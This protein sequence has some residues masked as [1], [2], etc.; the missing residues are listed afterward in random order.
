MN[1]GI[2][3]ALTAVMCFLFFIWLYLAAKRPPGSP[4]SAIE[5]FACCSMISLFGFVMGVIV[6]IWAT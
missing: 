2:K 4:Q 1:I 3:I 5:F 6:A